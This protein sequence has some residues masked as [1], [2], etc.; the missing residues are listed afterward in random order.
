[1]ILNRSEEPPRLFKFKA[2]ISEIFEEDFVSGQFQKSLLESLAQMTK[3]HG[4][5]IFSCQ[6]HWLEFFLFFQAQN[7]NENFLILE[8]EHSLKKRLMSEEDLFEHP[9]SC[10]R[11]TEFASEQ[12]GFTSEGRGLS[13]MKV[14]DFELKMRSFS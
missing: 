3:H 11:W 5:R 12:E 4:V 9:L 2:R 10:E 8:L 13:S 6:I 14:G 1:M 7:Y